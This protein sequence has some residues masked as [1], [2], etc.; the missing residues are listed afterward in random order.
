MGP[1]TKRQFG[2][3]RFLLSPRMMHK[4]CMSS[5]AVESCRGMHSS[6]RWTVL[7]AKPYVSLCYHPLLCSLPGLP[8]CLLQL[9]AHW[10]NCMQKERPGPCNGL[11]RPAGRGSAGLQPRRPSRPVHSTCPG[12]RPPVAQ[13]SHAQDCRQVQSETFLENSQ[14]MFRLAGGTSS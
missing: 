8:C 6:E 4:M 10:P 13:G 14:K 11:Q 1:S 9:R 5:I 7:A 12:R 3:A 2:P